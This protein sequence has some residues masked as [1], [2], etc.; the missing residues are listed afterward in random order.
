MLPISLR[1]VLLLSVCRLLGSYTE[2][3]TG[4]LF[5]EANYG[6]LQSFLYQHGN[7][8]TPSLRH[9]LFLHAIKSIVF[10][11]S[12]GVIH[13]DLRPDNLLVHGTWP[14]SLDLC[15]YD[16]GGLTCEDLQL[17]GGKLPNSGFYNPNATWEPTY[18]ADIFG[19][20]L[21]L[22][23]I[24]TGHW[25]FRATTG[26]F[27]ST[28]EMEEYEADAGSRF[29]ACKFPNVEEPFRERDYFG[30]DEQIFSGYRNYGKRFQFIKVLAWVKYVFC[31]IWSVSSVKQSPRPTSK[32][33]LHTSYARVCTIPRTLK[34]PPYY[35]MA[36]SF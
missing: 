23:T 9:K 27:A 18:S 31:V 28:E 13:S 11:H 19:L 12:K 25:P 7:N 17:Y 26:P 35:A 24:V 32:L 16:F 2:F 10:I 3:P 1:Q 29:A 22:Y 6:N 21:V 8:I 15:L 5:V 36:L 14:L 33:A 30:G 34:L 20:N 4:L